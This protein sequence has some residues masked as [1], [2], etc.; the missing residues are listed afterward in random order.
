AP[1][2]HETPPPGAAELGFHASAA[3]TGLGTWSYDGTLR[4]VATTDGKTVVHWSPT[5]LHPRLTSDTELKADTLP[6][7]ASKITDSSG[8][9]IDAYRSLKA[10]A[11]GFAD[12]LKA[13]PG[14]TPGKG[15]VIAG[16][17]SGTPL[18]TLHTFVKPKP[19]KP[20]KLTIDGRLQAA[21]EQAVAAQGQNGERVASLVA[22]EPS[23]GRILAMANSQPGFNAAFTGRTAPG[24]TM[25]IITSAALL[26][27]GVSTGTSA[28]CTTHLYVYGKE[29]HNE[30]GS[31]I[32]GATL[33]DDFAASCNTGFISLRDRL[34]DDDLG[35][36]ARDVF[37]VG[38]TWHTGLPNFD[39]SVPSP[40]GDR[41]EKAAQ[42]IGQGKVQMNPLAMASVAATVRSGVFREPILLPGLPQQ[43]AARALPP[44]VAAQLRTLMHTTAVSGTA[45]HVMSGLGSLPMGAKTGTA[46][47]GNHLDSWFTAYRG[48]LAAAAMVEGGGH[49]ADA[50]GPAVRS[51]LTAGR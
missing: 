44:S 10:Q 47:V 14:G 51:V 22:I 24:S 45:D 7:A 3:L 40:A 41:T 5:V 37:G 4:M 23:T 34:G 11:A 25:K 33:R 8:R 28:P 20:L 19:G 29:F 39:G 9:S 13:Q 27:H 36:E 42:L 48:D 18:A 49:G 43:P 17:E 32:P 6:P 16:A 1:T 15:V 21:A 26:E 12:A 38:M 46:E 50:A 31:S 2:P 35:A 30:E